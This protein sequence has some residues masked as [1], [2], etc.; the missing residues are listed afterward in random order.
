MATRT[1]RPTSQ[2]VGQAIPLP[3]EYARLSTPDNPIGGLLHYLED[4]YQRTGQPPGAHF[5]I[6]DGHVVEAQPGWLVRNP[7]IWPT[8]GAGLAIGIPAATGELSAG[9]AGGAAASTTASVST[10]GGAGAAGRAGTAAVMD[11][12][13]G[14]APAATAGVAGTRPWWQDLIAPGLAAGTGLLGAQI[15]STGIREAAEIQAAYLREAL[16]YEKERDKYLR[17]TEASR[18]ADVTGRLQPYIATG[19]T[20]NDRM[21]AL[22]GLNPAGH[23]YTPPPASSASIPQNRGP[24]G[25]GKRAGGQMQTPVLPTHQTLPEAGPAAEMGI[26]AQ[27]QTVTL[28]APDGTVRTVPADQV[29]HFRARGAVMVA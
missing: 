24:V 17:E 21:A 6:K 27:G 3:P 14:V 2:P 11:P 19:Q 18:Y 9:G 5:T 29:E 10:T 25:W 7:W 15:Q 20:A 26:Q 23:G 8:I 16:A 13:Y 1:R 22:L 4:R 12:W 28:R